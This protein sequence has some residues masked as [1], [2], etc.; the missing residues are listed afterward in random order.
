MVGREKL[1]YVFDIILCYYV[2]N[3]QLPEWEKYGW[4]QTGSTH[5]QHST[6]PSF[7]D[8]GCCN[9]KQLCLYELQ[10]HV[11]SPHAG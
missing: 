10:H 3:G 5:D 1:K 4:P 9:T 6:H 2:V 11:Q 7:K 8:M